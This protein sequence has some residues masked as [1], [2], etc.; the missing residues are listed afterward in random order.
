MCALELSKH[1]LGIKLK[2]DLPHFAF[3]MIH[4]TCIIVIPQDAANPPLKHQDQ[5]AGSPPPQ[6]HQNA[7]WSPLQQGGLLVQIVW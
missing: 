4:C 7:A 2:F 6:E 5:Q 3:H 1:S